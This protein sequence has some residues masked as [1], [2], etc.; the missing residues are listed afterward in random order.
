VIGVHL[1]GVDYALGGDLNNDEVFEE[2][3]EPVTPVCPGC[4]EHLDLDDTAS[5]EWRWHDDGSV[6]CRC[7]W[8]QRLE[9]LP[10]R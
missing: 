1:D 2:E 10:R 4:G 6:M 9:E 7:G 8:T 3:W 5:I